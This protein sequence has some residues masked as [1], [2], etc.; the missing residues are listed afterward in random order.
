LLESKVHGQRHSFAK[1]N[2]G[3]LIDMSEIFRHTTTAKV[4]LGGHWEAYLK[5]R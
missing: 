1:G 5:T 3:F 2:R 4:C